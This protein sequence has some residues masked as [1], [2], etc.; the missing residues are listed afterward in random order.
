MMIS[1]IKLNM[2]INIKEIKKIADGLLNIG[3]RDLIGYDVYRD[4]QYIGYTE[5]TE[6][7]DT[8]DELWY[9]VESCYNVVSVWD[10]G[11]SG[12]SNTACVTPQLNGPSSLSEIILAILLVN[13]ATLLECPAV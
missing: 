12:Y 1:K 8:S 11:T 2:E 7:L 13:H 5:E 10:E 4:N 9:L 6:Y 3:L